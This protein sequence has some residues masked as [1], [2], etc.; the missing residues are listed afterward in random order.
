MG[1]YKNYSISDLDRAAIEAGDI[2]TPYNAS[3]Q[4]DFVLISSVRDSPVEAL[5]H[6]LHRLNTTTF[7]VGEGPGICL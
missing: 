4:L 1:L 5:S 7:K 6:R 2:H 3:H